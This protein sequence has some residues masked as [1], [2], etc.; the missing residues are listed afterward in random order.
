MTMRDVVRASEY[1][2]L[3]V[4]AVVGGLV[5]MLV[6]I[7]MGVT[8]ALIPVAVPLGLVGLVIFVWGLSRHRR[9]GR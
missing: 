6:G 2:A 3:H 5:L 9:A 8:V 1:A 7:G 4:A